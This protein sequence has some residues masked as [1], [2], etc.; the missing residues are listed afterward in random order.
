M[1]P[2]IILSPPSLLRGSSLSPSAPFTIETLQVSPTIKNDLMINGLIDIFI[3]ISLGSHLLACKVPTDTPSS[4]AWKKLALI[5]TLVV[6]FLFWV[7]FG[8]VFCEII[9]ICNILISLDDDLMAACADK[10]A[11]DS[12]CSSWEVEAEEGEEVVLLE[13]PDG[14]GRPSPLSSPTSQNEV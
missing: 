10:S 2:F 9:G 4:A 8:L 3:P 12:Y 5:N 13:N 11:F 7:G 1:T 14:M 6:I